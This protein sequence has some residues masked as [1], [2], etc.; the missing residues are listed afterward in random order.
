[1]RWSSLILIGLSLASVLGGCGGDESAEWTVDAGALKLR[2]TESPWNMTFFDAEGNPV[3]VELGDTGDGPSG[4]L[5]MHLGPP[6]AGNGQQSALPQLVDGVPATPPARDS[7]WVHAT[8]VESSRTE[9]DSYMA[10]I[11][12][13]DPERKLELV[14]TRAADGVIQI[15]VKAASGDGVQALGVGF[16]AEPEERFVGFGERSNAVNQAGW[17]L[18]HYV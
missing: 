17:A 15:N 5:A 18:E 12:T 6:P 7:S 13:S 8:A 14:A 1:M 10:T 4:S 2:V 3:L 11:A 9:A 16:L